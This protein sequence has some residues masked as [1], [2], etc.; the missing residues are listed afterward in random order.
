MVRPRIDSVFFQP[1][2]RLYFIHTEDAFGMTL[3]AE[4]CGGKKSLFNR[5]GSWLARCLPCLFFF[6]LIL[7]NKV[8]RMTADW[9][10]FAQYCS[11]IPPTVIR[12]ACLISQILTSSVI[13]EEASLWTLGATLT[14]PNTF[15]EQLRSDA[16]IVSA[17]GERLK[18]LLESI[19]F[20]IE[21]MLSDRHGY[22]SHVWLP[23]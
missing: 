13:V 2:D 1:S 8:V 14:N 18:Y 23:E 9:S 4:S 16:F 7:L 15:K 11:F 3:Q 5:C 17:P 20:N 12:S 22:K 19:H 10:G 6:K 21:L